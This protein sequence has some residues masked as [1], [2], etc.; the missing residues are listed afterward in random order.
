[1]FVNISNQYLRP[2][3]GDIN[4]NTI[5]FSNIETKSEYELQNIRRV[6]YHEITHALAYSEDIFPYYIDQEGNSYNFCLIQPYKYSD[7]TIQYFLQH[8]KIKDK[9]S[10]FYNC[11]DSELN[12]GLPISKLDKSHFHQQLSI[13]DIMRPISDSLD[14]RITI[15]LLTLFD[16]TGWYI[17]S[18]TNNYQDNQNYNINKYFIDNQKNLNNL[19]SNYLSISIKND[20]I[21]KNTTQN[22]YMIKMTDK[23]NNDISLYS[24][25]FL[26]YSSKKNIDSMAEKTLFGKNKGCNFVNLYCYDENGNLFEEYCD[27]IKEFG[28]QK[29]NFHYEAISNC[30]LL[31]SEVG[32]RCALWFPLEDGNCK[33]IKTNIDISVNF[34]K[35]GVNSK[36][37]NVLLN[38]K[39]EDAIC[40]EA[41]CDNKVMAVNAIFNGK[42]FISIYEND[43]PK[44]NYFYI[45]EHNMKV[46]FPA[47]YERFCF[48]ENHK[49]NPDKGFK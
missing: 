10:E 2:L 35:H 13:E 31:N 16:I 21:I 8:P 27:P 28:K 42:N 34:M 39:N 49:K 20:N 37:F 12:K 48:F 4:F 24:L 43:K 22:I 17:V 14:E 18:E 41:F 33:N 6:V 3:A 25:M 19:N 7:D 5:H 47:S 36:C 30:K 15:F 38:S 23:T 1:M 29:C 45:K 44:T 46:K 11:R 32:A 26:P 40:L 9:V